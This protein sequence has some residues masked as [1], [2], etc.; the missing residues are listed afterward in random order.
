MTVTI[1]PFPAPAVTKEIITAIIHEIGRDVLFFY[2]T[3]LSGCNLCS[4]DPV[5]N[6]S[7]DSFCPLCNGEYWIP[8]FSGVTMS[9]K[10]TWGKSELKGWETG[11]LVDTGDCQVTVIHSDYVEDIIFSSEYVVVDNRELNVKD[12]ILRGVPS[13]NR[14]LV[15]LKE[16]ERD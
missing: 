11:G 14:I 3:S 15:V 12:I 5:T 2:P 13:V 7:T 8:T 9:G 6:T 10:V 1:A 16:K 4:L